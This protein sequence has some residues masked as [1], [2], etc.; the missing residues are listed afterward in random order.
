MHPNH[1]LPNPLLL[2]LFY[3]A[4]AKC[5]HACT[6]ARTHTCRHTRNDTRTDVTDKDVRT[7]KRD[8]HNNR[9]GVK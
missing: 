6:R 5:T 4:L 1:A 3:Q 7:E 2:L 8:R 9:G